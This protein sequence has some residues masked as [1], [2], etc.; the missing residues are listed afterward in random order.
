VVYLTA[1]SEE[2]L[3]ELKEGE[4]Y[5]IG[6]ICDHNRYKVCTRSVPMN[7]W[8]KTRKF[9]RYYSFIPVFDLPLRS[10]VISLP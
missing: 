5:V 6:G 1:D 8:V 7:S 4:I 3:M 9:S 10:P 2:E